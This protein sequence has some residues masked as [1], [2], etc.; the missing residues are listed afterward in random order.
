MGED[1]KRSSAWEQSINTSQFHSCLLGCLSETY[2]KFI[3]LFHHGEIPIYLGGI[4]RGQNELGFMYDLSHL[5]CY[6]YSD[7]W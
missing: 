7:R 3:H 5:Q 6:R 2:S 1:G 4:Q